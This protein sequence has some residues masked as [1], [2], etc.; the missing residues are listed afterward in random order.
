MRHSWSYDK[1]IKTWLN[2]QNRIRGISV[3]NLKYIERLAICRKE[4]ARL[5]CVTYFLLTKCAE[6]EV[7][8]SN[9]RTMMYSLSN[10]KNFVICV[11]KELPQYKVQTPDM[12]YRKIFN[13]DISKIEKRC[14]HVRAICKEN[15]RLS[16][17]YPY[18]EQHG[19]LD[20][21]NEVDTTNLESTNM[22][23]N[24]LFD[25][26]QKWNNKHKKEVALW[27]EKIEEEKRISDAY[28]KTQQE[29][30]MEEKAAR[31]KAIQEQK[32]YEN[33]ILENERAERKRE[34]QIERSYDHLYK[35]VLKC[36]DKGKI[37]VF[38]NRR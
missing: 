3:E 19:F 6:D 38:N 10:Q 29:K 7:E 5:A 35:S 20:V 27:N 9:Y 31:K 12:D 30:S 24:R 18:F 16:S 34:K 14:D 32:E 21:F 8:E 37:T 33:E 15:I 36:E 22:I 25:D 17:F 2:D 26:I 13:R 28:H 4:L 23:F 1:N 11:L